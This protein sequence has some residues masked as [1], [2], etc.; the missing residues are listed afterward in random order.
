M[1]GSFD[2][3]GT[4]KMLLSTNVAVAS[5]AVGR[6]HCCGKKTVRKAQVSRLQTNTFFFKIVYWHE[7]ESRDSS[8]DADLDKHLER[9]YVQRKLAAGLSRIWQDVQTKVRLLVVAK[10]VGTRMK[11]NDFLHLVKF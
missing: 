5:K 6:R 9:Q 7:V 3:Y 11:I 8:A 1:I 2:L 4:N 10:E